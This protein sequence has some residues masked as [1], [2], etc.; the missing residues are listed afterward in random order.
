MAARKN[1]NN[2]PDGAPDRS[3]DLVGNPLGMKV[4]PDTAAGSS[5]AGS[6][7]PPVKDL[8]RDV[9]DNAVSV[10]DSLWFADQRG[11]L[12]RSSPETQPYGD[13]PYLP[14]PPGSRSM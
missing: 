7:P 2:T 6:V 9:L 1:T 10:T 13:H 14:D 12:G 4:K 11:S 8:D 5:I 3:D